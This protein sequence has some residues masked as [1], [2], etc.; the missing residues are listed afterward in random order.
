[1]SSQIGAHARKTPK[2]N[3]CRSALVT[4][5]LGRAS[6]PDLF[7][8][9]AGSACTSIPN[10]TTN[11]RAGCGKS[12]CPVRREGEAERPLPTSITESPKCL[13]PP[14]LDTHFPG[15]VLRMYRQVRGMNVH[16][17]PFPAHP[18]EDERAAVQH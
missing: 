6:T 7:H 4:E 13:G 2:N 9:G 17:E 18:A 1:M 11:W 12:A 8:R 3:R 5:R 14:A 16:D 10:R 15:A